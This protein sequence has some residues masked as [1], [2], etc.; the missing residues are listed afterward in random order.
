MTLRRRL[1]L[2]YGL[3]FC[4]ALGLLI[5][6]MYFILQDTLLDST[7]TALRE[8]AGVV[9]RTVVLRG[10]QDLTPAELSADIFALAPAD[11]RQELDAPGIHIRVYNID[12]R[13]LAISSGVAAQM[14]HDPD[15][16]LVAANGGEEWRTTDV[17]GSPIRVTWQPL[18]F[19][20]DVRAVIQLSES[21]RPME[22]TLAQMR[23]LLIAIG[24]AAVV[25]GLAA[26]WLLA[27][28]ALRPVRRLTSTVAD[29]SRT[30]AFDRRLP[31]PKVNDEIGE[32]AN[33]F[34]DLLDHLSDLFDRQRALVADTSHELRT[35]LHVVRG[36]AELLALDPPLQ[37]RREALRD[38]EEEVDRMTRLV[39]DLLFLADADA[40]SSI[41]R[42]AIRLDSIVAA[43]YS[44]AL[45]IATREDGTRIVRLEANDPV[46]IRGDEG[47]MTQL[48]WNL[49]E[50]GIRYTP[51][52]GTVQ[53][54]LRRRGSIAELTVSDTG[55]GIAQEHIS[56][57][58]ERFYRVDKGR[59]R[60]VGGTG[61]GL[62]IVRQITEAHGGQ[63]RVRSVPGEGSTFTVVL[64]VSGADSDAVADQR[65]VTPL[66]IPPD[67]AVIIPP[68][69][70]PLRPEGHWSS[71]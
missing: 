3:G 42:D 12:G 25:G 13:V 23:I 64:P 61:L 5:G 58:F 45:G 35:P 30:G 16:I 37:L 8:R 6:G 31:Q 38:I 54:F 44:D 51:A 10:Q 20:G 7:D 66:P 57:I 17:N 62:S 55:I 40:D 21:L 49:V 48:V 39:G 68:S 1:T 43:V 27:R 34:N 69:Q 41:A 4:A 36:N 47:R 63:V 26:G 2:S 71:E 11:A 19:A 29:I 28:H 18:L 50:N 59:S 14:P 67:D 52:G 65:S 33:T 22:T 53:I 9:E 46:V 60:E 56:R 70:Q 24:G 32:L 15:A